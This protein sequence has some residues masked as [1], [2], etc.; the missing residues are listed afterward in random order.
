LRADDRAHDAKTSEEVGVLR[1]AAPEHIQEH[2]RRCRREDVDSL[3]GRRKPLYIQLERDAPEEIGHGRA[4]L[5]LDGDLR[6]RLLGSLSCRAVTRALKA[7]VRRAQ[8]GADDAALVIGTAKDLVEATAAHVLVERYGSF[9]ETANLPTC[10][11]RHMSPSVSRRP[12]THES[13]ARAP[14]GTS[15]GSCSRLRVR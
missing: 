1:S 9:Q 15:S 13:P 14:S 12:S 4:R 2:E 7:Q 5:T 10:L 3:A 8:E 11:A 6:P